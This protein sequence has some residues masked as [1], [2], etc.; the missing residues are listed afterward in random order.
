MLI[1]NCFDLV[2]ES[3]EFGVH[4]YDNDV[5]EMRPFFF[6]VGPAFVPRCRV[7]PFENVDLFPLF[8]DILNLQCPASNGTLENLKWC[9][10]KYRRS[11]IID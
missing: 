9:L 7:P 3:S 5:P 10:T 8:C 6:G 1:F 2:N 11:K 4:G